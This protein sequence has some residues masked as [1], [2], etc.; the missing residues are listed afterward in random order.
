MEDITITF[1][2]EEAQNLINLLDAAVKAHGLTASQVALPLALKI[3]EAVNK[4]A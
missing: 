4:A 1:T 3:S 2:K